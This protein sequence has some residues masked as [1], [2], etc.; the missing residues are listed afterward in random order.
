M[1]VC[2]YI[3][4]ETSKLC[5]VTGTITLAVVATNKEKASRTMTQSGVTPYGISS[6]FTF[7]RRDRPLCSSRYKDGLDR[8]LH[9]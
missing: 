2:M 9:I 8:S 6:N 1:Y 4:T 5:T 3:V 7:V